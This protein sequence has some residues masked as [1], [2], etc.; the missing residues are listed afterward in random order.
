MHHVAER[1]NN[2]CTDVNKWFAN[3]AKSVSGIGLV[4]FP[5]HSHTRWVF[6]I[7]YHPTKGF[8]SA[9][10]R[11][12]ANFAVVGCE[13]L[14]LLVSLYVMAFIVPHC[15]C[16]LVS[17]LLHF[18]FIFLDGI[19]MI[20][21]YPRRFYF[22]SKCPLVSKMHECV[23]CGDWAF[24]YPVNIETGAIVVVVVGQ[25][26]PRMPSLLARSLACFALHFVF[27]THQPDNPSFFL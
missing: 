26:G 9:A 23:R 14:T 27:C 20:L 22:L 13:R 10:E 3:N 19:P 24:Y 12:A 15:V 4:L 17:F 5:S 2:C 25:L 7:F 8:F 18:L 21:N 16:H 6:L 1:E 11:T